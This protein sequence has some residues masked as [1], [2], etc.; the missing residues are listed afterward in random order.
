MYIYLNICARS[1]AVLAYYSRLNNSLCQAIS[2][3]LSSFFYPFE[4]L[5]ECDC[6]CFYQC[7]VMGMIIFNIYW[8]LNF[9]EWICNQ[10][11]FQKIYMICFFGRILNLKEMDVRQK[12][13]YESDIKVTTAKTTFLIPWTNVSENR[14]SIF[15]NRRSNRI[16]L[17]SKR[18]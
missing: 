13:S 4:S 5:Y 16:E 15:N 8:Y 7:L 14:Q 17:L 11:N 6:I 9:H 1:I 12:Q 2:I 18:I 3:Q 10:L